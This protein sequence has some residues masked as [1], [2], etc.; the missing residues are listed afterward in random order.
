MQVMQ[1]SM[2]TLLVIVASATCTLS[3]SFSP[4]PSLRAQSSSRA[5]A[6]V[7]G[8]GVRAPLLRRRPTAPK[9]SVN[10]P[11]EVVAPSTAGDRPS[12]HFSGDGPAKFKIVLLAGF[13]TFNRELYRRAADRAATQCPGLEIWVATDRDISAHPEAL[14]GALR[15]ADIFFCSL[16]FDFNEVTWLQ[17]RIADIPVRFVFE[18]A[19]ELMSS[20][21]VGSFTMKQTPGKK[22]GMP[23]AVKAVL[24]KFSSTREED[25]LDGYTKFLKS[26]PKLLKLLPGDTARDLRRWSAPRPAPTRAALT[27]RSRRAARARLETYSFWN[28][29]GTDNVA[30]M[31][32][33][34]AADFSELEPAAPAAP[35]A[36]LLP[37]VPL[38]PPSAAP[39]AGLPA[40]LAPLAP[41]FAAVRAAL[42]ALG[43][44]PAAEAAGAAGAAAGG[45]RA[46]VEAP[47]RGLV[48]PDR[49]GHYFASPREYLDWYLAARPE[50]AGRPVVGVLL[51][52]KHVVSELPYIPE[53]V[54]HMEGKG[55]L[56]LPLFITGVDG[57]IAVR[58][59]LTSRWE[60]EQVA[61]GTI[62]RNPTL[63]AD[64]VDV[65]AVVSTIGFPLVGGPAGSME[66]ARQAEL[67]KEI[68]LAK[69]VPYFVA[70]PL[71]IQDVKSWFE[72]GIGGLQSVVL[73]ALPEL[74]GAIDTI[75]LGG[76]CCGDKAFCNANRDLQGCTR[77]GGEIRLVTERLD[78]LAE[79]INKW[80]ALRRTAAAERRVAVVLYGYP[81]GLGAT[82][83]AALLNVPRS[84]HTLLT[85]MREEGYDVGALPEDPEELLREVPPPLPFPLVLSGHAASL[86][87]Y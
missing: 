26:G 35:A 62:V 87:P 16:V 30:A 68:L 57:H 51:Y 13:E 3:Y 23:P 33:A 60:A 65:D 76:L 37:S 14:D 27:P 64:A 56:P 72:Q 5:A 4:A 10:E 58:D 82:G 50:A 24:S 86:T 22:Q 77:E 36:P 11:V 18:S 47:Q 59:S 31:F 43:L 81:P 41:L 52:R 2:M 46:P 20:T 42:A 70:A 25:R 83:T 49:P 7:Q 45:A 38:V 21:Q 17:D 71:L 74:D 75:P 67:A 84:L 53:L 15:G 12:R 28:A 69:N 61:A 19:L 29:G 48:H 6:L 34:L 44:L 80:T 8:R 39:D 79:R 85:K 54:R 78:R 73:Y 40:A 32:L 55:L 66:G 63:S 9:M 1:R